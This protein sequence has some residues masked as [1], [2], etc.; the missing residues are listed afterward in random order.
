MSLQTITIELVDQGAGAPATIHDETFPFEGELVYG[1]DKGLELELGPLRR[2]L[3]LR[4]RFDPA[5]IVDDGL[6]LE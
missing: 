3:L 2:R 5:L 6:E 4:V 1:F